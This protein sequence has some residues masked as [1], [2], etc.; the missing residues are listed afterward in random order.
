MRTNQKSPTSSV[1]EPTRL[2]EVI[3]LG[4]DVHIECYVVVMKIDGS[5][6]QRAKRFTPEEFLEWVRTVCEG[7]DELHSC[8]EAGPFG[9]SLHRRLEQLG[10]SNH[11]IRPINWDEH[12]Q[13]VKTDARDATQMVLCLDGYLRGNPRSFSTVRVPS[14]AEERRRSLTRQRQSLIKER[15]RLAAKARGHVMYYG[16]RLQGEW[17]KPRR[18]GALREELEEHV[19]GLIEPLRCILVTVEEQLERLE[20][21]LEEMCTVA[22]PKGMGV[23]I[24]EQMEREVCDWSRFTSRKAVGSYTGLC[25]SEDTSDQRRF[26]GSITKHGNPR[27]R[28]MLIECVWLLLQWNK[29]Y[30]GIVKW[31]EQLLEA[32]LTRASKKKIIV[33]IARQFAVDW[34]RIRTAQIKPEQLGLV[35]KNA[36]IMSN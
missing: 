5:A 8:Y 25:P 27:L 17:W 6:P 36:P 32:K 19:L 14:E 35:M 10:I 26:Q 13:R 18:W 9:Y 1:Q 24:F 31:R 23:V 16:G 21:R 11:V 34:W 33:A 30:R 22:L 15:K 7:C 4:I 3:K 2:G 28:H 12:G 20:E 29:D